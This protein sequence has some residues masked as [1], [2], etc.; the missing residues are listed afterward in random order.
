MGVD[1]DNNVDLPVLSSY[2]QLYKHVHCR[3]R[4]IFYIF[5]PNDLHDSPVIQ[6]VIVTC[7]FF[8]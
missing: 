1:V 4:V 5:M 6:E 8:Q 2:V 3:Y 7:I